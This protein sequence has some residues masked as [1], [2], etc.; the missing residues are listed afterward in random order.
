VCR[1]DSDELIESRLK[2]FDSELAAS[3]QKLR[4]KRIVQNEEEE[5]LNQ[6][7]LQHVKLVEKQAELQADHKVRHM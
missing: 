7:R 5:T 4:E 3:N 6:L 1:Q 2:N